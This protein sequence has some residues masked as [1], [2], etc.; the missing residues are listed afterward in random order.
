MGLFNSFAWL[1]ICCSAVPNVD[2]ILPYKLCGLVNFV[3]TMLQM[4]FLL[5]ES[6]CHTVSS[7]HGQT[8]TPC[9]VLK[10]TARKT[11][12]YNK[13][14]GV[15]WTSFF[16]TIL[17]CSIQTILTSLNGRVWSFRRQKRKKEKRE[18]NRL[19]RSTT[20]DDR[21]TSKL[22]NPSTLSLWSDIFVSTGGK[23]RFVRV[24]GSSEN[25]LHRQLYAN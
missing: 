15:L 2:D 8:L 6:H 10:F 21:D 11:F 9:L 5:R 1:C 24:P 13:S 19:T 25:S 18:A 3:F 4:S 16:G 22:R 12:S 14:L 7:G 17:F 20:R 23:F